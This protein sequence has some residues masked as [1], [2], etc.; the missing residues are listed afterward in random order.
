MPP[1]ILSDK[2]TIIAVVLVVAIIILLLFFFPSA[3]AD[4]IPDAIN[5]TKHVAYPHTG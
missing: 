3:P 4:T 5:V 1:A 2:K